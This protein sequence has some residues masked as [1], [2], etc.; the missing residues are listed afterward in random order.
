MLQFVAQIDTMQVL[1]H[2]PIVTPTGLL[3]SLPQQPGTCHPTANSSIE[4]LSNCFCQCMDFQ[5]KACKSLP[6]P[7]RAVRAQGWQ[8]FM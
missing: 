2:W 8:A 7:Q 5:V 6:A 1:Q 4:I 3:T